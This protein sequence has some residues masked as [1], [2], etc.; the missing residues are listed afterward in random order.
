MTNYEY[1][2]HFRLDPATETALEQI[3]RMTFMTKS[4][5]MRR[6]V[7]EGVAKDVQ[8]YVEESGKTLGAANVLKSV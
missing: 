2:H 3:C 7:R 8:V 1:R 4:A 5:I 6:Y